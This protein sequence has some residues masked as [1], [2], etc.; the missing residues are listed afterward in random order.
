MGVMFMILMSSYGLSSLLVFTLP[1]GCITC[2]HLTTLHS[3]VRKIFPITTHSCAMHSRLTRLDLCSQHVAQEAGSPFQ[4]TLP[5][6]LLVPIAC[7]TLARYDTQPCVYTSL[8]LKSTVKN[9]IAEA[10]MALLHTLAVLASSKCNHPA[11]TIEHYAR[12]TGIS[13]AGTLPHIT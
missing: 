4:Q 6:V 7:V 9:L 8:Q 5:I 1:V 3:H 11:N 2:V 12:V 13:S 10:D